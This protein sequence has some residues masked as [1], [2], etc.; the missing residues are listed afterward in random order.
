MPNFVVG[1]T[2]LALMEAPTP[3]A[4]FVVYAA[5]CVGGYATIYMVYPETRGLSL[6]EAASLL[7]DDSWGRPVTGVQGEPGVQSPSRQTRLAWVGSLD[8]LIHIGAL[9]RVSIC[10]RW[11]ALPCRVHLGR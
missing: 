6:E 10:G 7:E 2:F 5:V 4:A 8:G 1:L 11:A 9:R 3:S